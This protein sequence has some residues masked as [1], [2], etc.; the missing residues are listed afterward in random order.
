MTDTDQPDVDT[1]VTTAL[2]TVPIAR[3]HIATRLLS[4]VPNDGAPIGNITLKALTRA[5]GNDDYDAARDALKVAGLIVSGGGQGG[6][7][8]LVSTFH[9]AELTSLSPQ[10]GSIE[11]SLYPAIKVALE[12]RYVG[13]EVGRWTGAV[14]DITGAAGRKSTGG[15]WS[16]PDLT[17]VAYRL[18]GLLPGPYVEVHTYEVKTVSAVD[19]DALHETCAH[20]TRAHRSTLLVDIEDDKQL[21]KVTRLASTALE[22]GVG[23]VTFCDPGELWTEWVAP[24]LNQPDVIKLDAF[25][26]SQ[27]SAVS[28]AAI[29]RWTA[30]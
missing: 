18:L 7:V 22:L 13:D 26:T 25:L 16:R 10:A 29:R 17:A 1:L 23:L 11:T 27:L 24:A 21:P 14:V 2:S 5:T 9:G 19:L 30:T 3:R 12:H 4:Q 20:R 28:Q 6:S 15:K 8:K